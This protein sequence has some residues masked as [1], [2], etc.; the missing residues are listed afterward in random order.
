[1]RKPHAVLDLESRRNKGLKIERLL[2]LASRSDQFRL[3]EIGTGS[4][5][6]AHYFA[7]HPAL[8]CEVVAVDVEDHRVVSDGYEFHRVSDT[9]LPFGDA[10]FDVVISNHVIEHVGAE[11]AQRHHLRE[12]CRILA[13][14]G[15][16]YLAV[17]NRWMLME[18]HYRLMF[19]S[20][21][22]RVLRSPYLRLLRHETHYDC[23][24]LTQGRLE[25]LMREANLSFQNL[26]VPALH[27]MVAIEGGGGTARMLDR[28]PDR[29][30]K[31]LT[32]IFPTLIYSLRC[33]LIG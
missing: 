9:A 18:P 22:P 1:M 3:L 2:D 13:P 11:E 27:E 8:S 17:P 32:P 10:S 24:P 26:C 28:V 4:G 25:R 23:E 15:V 21:L 7:T 19:L 33:N 31:L 6:I 5:G 29:L 14:D 16:G 12:V 20:W 30:L